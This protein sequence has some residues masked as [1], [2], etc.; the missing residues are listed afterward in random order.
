MEV[1]QLI[2]SNLTENQIEQQKMVKNIKANYLYTFLSNT[3]LTQGLWMIY[4]VSKGQSLLAVGLLESIFHLT[5]FL[6]EV[7]TGAIA[8]IYGRKTSRLLSRILSIIATILLIFANHFVFFAISFIFSALSYNL[9]SGS[10]EALI[11]DSLKAI[12][13]ENTFMN[14]FGKIEVSYQLSSTIAL[15]VG[16]YLGKLNYHYA[17]VGTIIITFIAII[18]GAYAFTEATIEKVSNIDLNFLD[19]IKCQIQNSLK[20]FKRTRK[21]GYLILLSMT[22]S[23]V[24]TSFFFYLQ[25]YFKFQGDSEFKIGVILSLSSLIGAL[26]ASQTDRIEKVIKEKG[27]LLYFPIFMTAALFG[28]AYTSYEIIFYILLT[29]GECIMYVAVND[30][31]NKLIDSEF[32][33][34]ILSFMSMAFSLC[35]ILLFPIIGWIG[36][37]Y[38]LKVAFICTSYLFLIISLVNFVNLK[39]NLK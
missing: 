21:A 38:S 30:Y 31:I 33:A 14:V 17:F 11:Y 16:G 23:S 6:M 25:N 1:I 35:M 20:T 9:E 39:R 29:L 19:S 12:N 8:D 22:M 10:G 5:S 27:I 32:R 28:I 4:L 13:T 15:I 37:H 26:G 3:N 24:A 18:Y 2:K 34:T 36:D 7:P